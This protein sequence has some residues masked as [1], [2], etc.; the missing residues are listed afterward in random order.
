MP[1]AA[2]ISQHPLA[3]HAAGEVIGSILDAVGPAPDLLVLSVTGPFAGAIDDIAHA[4]STLLQPATFVGATAVSVLASG[5]EVED[6]GAVM[7]FAASWQGRLRHGGRWLRTVTFDAV[8]HDDGWQ[9]TGDDALAEADGTLLLLA[10]PQSFPV[11]AF[12]DGLAARNPYL[13][14]VGGLASAPP[15]LTPNH[16]VV[17]GRRVDRGAVGVVLPAGVPVRTVLSQGFRAVGDP[18]V[19]TAARDG[20]VE[21]I[22]GR[23]ALDVVMATADDASPEDRRGMARALHLGIAVHEPAAAPDRED[24]LGRRVLGADRTTGA[25]AVDATVEVGTTV[26][27][28]VRDAES[29]D[30][31]LRAALAGESPAAALAFT[32]SDRG[33]A[34]FGRDDHDAE[35]L[36]DHVVGHASAGLFTAGEIAP[37]GPHGRSHLHAGA[38]AALL[39]D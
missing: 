10:E 21:E 18:L 3:T 31:D 24:L 33:R 16:L 32:G 12:V 39:F 35:L 4:M 14:I 38:T 37:L 8:R 30:E 27:F 26:Q 2:A 7:A 20:L 15:T 1:F 25:I 9:V 17:D 5:R 36:D 23:P 34:L 22:A 28:L 29:A 19:V 13:S 6:Q 11:D